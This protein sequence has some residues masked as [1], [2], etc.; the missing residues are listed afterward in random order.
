VRLALDPE[1]V[2]AI[3][4]AVVA[5]LP[6]PRPVVSPWMDTK[7][8]AAYAGTTPTALHKAM[9]ERRVRFS[10]DAPGGKAWFKAAWID[11]WRES[12]ASIPLPHP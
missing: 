1:D 9:A 3:A 5:R 4:D 6:A 2:A 12:G 11:E 8:A 7:S 10:Q